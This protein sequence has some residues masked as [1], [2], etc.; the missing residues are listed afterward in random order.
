ME[1]LVRWNFELAD[2]AMQGRRPAPAR[3]LDHLMEG[4]ELFDHVAAFYDL[5]DDGS[6]WEVFRRIFDEPRG[7]YRRSAGAPPRGL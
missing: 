5:G 7:A 1:E 6:R 3:A 4:L 2:A